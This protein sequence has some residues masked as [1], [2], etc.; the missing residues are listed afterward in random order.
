M[1][2]EK[3]LVGQING[4]YGVKGEVKVFSHTEPRSNILSYSP[5]LLKIKGE[6]QAFKVLK[7]QILQGGKSIVA[8]L[9][10]ITDRDVA[11]TYMGVEIAILPSQLI[12]SEDEFYWRDLIGCEVI[13]QDQVS[14][15]K[16][17]ELV[18]TG[19][20]D[21]L[22]VGLKQGSE[23]ILIPFVFDEFIQQIDLNAQKIE[24]YWDLSEDDL[25][26]R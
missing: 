9:D 8:L 24:V 1:S 17:L 25:S 23:T 18:E 22:R 14:L 21:V 13:N 12:H 19:V 6:W 7:G 10:G 4:I 11:K 20:H 2:E 26:A 16:V 5:W 15:G 3:I